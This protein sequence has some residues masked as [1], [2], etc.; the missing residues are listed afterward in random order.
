[1]HTFA[2][3]LGLSKSTCRTG[4]L[5]FNMHG[6]NL[7]TKPAAFLRCLQASEAERRQSSPLKSP[8]LVTRLT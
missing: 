8:G 5:A 3:S 6:I 4:A 2:S 1:M 7:V